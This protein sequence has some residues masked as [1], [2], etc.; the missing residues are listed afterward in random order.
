[1]NLFLMSDLI[2]IN[3]SVGML[4]ISWKELETVHPHYWMRKGVLQFKS[5]FVML[6]LFLRETD[7]T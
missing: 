6:I 2:E 4:T 7:R 3:V 1:M 5:F